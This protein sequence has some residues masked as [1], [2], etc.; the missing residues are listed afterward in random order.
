MAMAAAS[1]AVQAASDVEPNYNLSSAH[2]DKI[3]ALWPW[4]A[5]W[6]KPKT[7]RRDLV[8]AAALLVAEIERLDRINAPGDGEKTMGDW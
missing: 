6:W 2:R 4:G 5:H 3:P 7:G 8:R 1:Y